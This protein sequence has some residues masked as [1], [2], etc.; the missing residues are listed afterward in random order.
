MSVRITKAPDE[1][2]EEI[3]KTAHQL[4]LE[5]GFDGTKVSDIVKALG[6]SQ[7]TFY[8][9]FTSK[10]DIIDEIVTGYIRSITNGTREIIEKKDMASYEKLERMSDL[11]LMINIKQ[12]RDIH[13]IKG[14]DIHERI[15]RRLIIDYVPI[16]LKAFGEGGSQDTLFLMEIFVVA[17]NILFDPGIFK[18]DRLERNSRINFMVAF[19]EKCFHVPENSFSFYKRL[20]GFE[21]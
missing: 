9:Y 15:L 20:M 5:K 8:Y 11:Q 18:W 6:V 7:G 16:M 1:R 14:V 19:M 12:N 17:A 21:E 13:T 2:R 3:I 4:F 10:D